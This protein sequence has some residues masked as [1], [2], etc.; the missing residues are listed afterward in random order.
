MNWETI[1][2]SGEVRGFGLLLAIVGVVVSGSVLAL[3]RL[4]RRRSPPL[5]Y[6]VA[7]AGVVGLLAAPVM[8][9]VSQS[10]EGLFAV[11][12]E[13]TVK[14]PAEQLA[15]V[16]APPG[17]EDANAPIEATAGAGDWVGAALIG[18]WM[19]GI[20]VGLVNIGRSIWKQRRALAGAPW[21]AAWW[22]EERR[23]ALAE[24]VG[25][26]SF[27]PLWQSPF[28]PLPMVLGVWRPR[29]VVPEAAPAAWGQ[30][31]WEAVL[32]HE[33]AHIARRDPL[34]ALAQ[35][36]AVVLFW[37][38]PLVHLLSRR[39]H[40]LRETICD[41]YALEGSCDGFAYAEL[42]VET[43]ERLV[44]LRTMPVSVGLLESAHGGL[45]E[46]IARLLAEEKR[47]MTKVT[48]AAKLVG[49]A[50]LTVACLTITAAAAYS[51][52]PPP[53][54]KIQIK[55]LIDGKEFD[56]TDAHLMQ[57]LEAVQKK[58]AAD[59]AAEAH[60][61]LGIALD[62][63]GV[64][65]SPD[66]K[67]LY[68]TD[69]DKVFI[70]DAAT[71]K[72]VAVT[73][74]KEGAAFGRFMGHV[75]LQ[76]SDPRI[77]E[78]VKQAEALKPGSGAAVRMALLE[79]QLK[80]DTEKAQRERAALIEIL[81]KQA[82]AITPGSGAK[83][84]WHLLT[85]G[86]PPTIVPAPGTPVLMQYKAVPVVPPPGHKPVFAP[87]KIRIG[88]SADGGKFLLLDIGGNQIK[89]DAETL[90]KLDKVPAPPRSKPR[91][92]DEEAKAWDVLYKQLLDLQA[93]GQLKLETPLAKPGV[94]GTT[95]VPDTQPAAKPGGPKL[96]TGQ[97]A[98]EEMDR[99][100]A[101]FLEAYQA[102]KAAATVP[103]PPGSSVPD[104]ALRMEEMARQ[105]DRLNAELLELRKR[106]DQS[107]AK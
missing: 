64:T 38:C 61:A 74:V 76:T 54:R 103:A 50:A 10:L 58:A 44:N 37:W 2:F 104:H 32:L 93:S 18:L 51:Q 107:K 22:T 75:A 97:S 56:L 8:V 53:Q 85:G 48:L 62:V 21:Q 16:L 70:H 5:R 9:G 83:V 15:Q 24:K 12:T 33:A 46:R 105:L 26:S 65:F 90:R 36:I 100:R 25:L 98:A 78:L 87:E 13:E 31:Q 57:H 52:A 72:I 28:A 1:A 99:R 42:L 29:I 17:V 49:A 102:K 40:E 88:I 89:L 80:A 43:A 34:A 73:A 68:R 92:P 106:L 7:F 27:P 82:E 4:L 60:K 63:K 35:R 47:P 3:G 84:R 86:A 66:G 45:E 96:K 81:V 41:D 23:Q 91:G 69:G 59:Q 77:E 67:L 55:I 20:T 39:L 30:S 101:E 94:P 95:G 19:L 79:K 71:G 6:A 11:T 14:I